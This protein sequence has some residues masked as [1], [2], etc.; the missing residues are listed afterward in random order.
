MKE[1]L[2]K[3]EDHLDACIWRQRYIMQIDTHTLHAADTEKQLLKRRTQT[4]HTTRGVYIHK[5][6]LQFHL[7]CMLSRMNLVS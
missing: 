1:C 3:E 5:R 2:T 4:S 7:N 6:V